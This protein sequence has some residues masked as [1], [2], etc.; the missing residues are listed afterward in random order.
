MS[1]GSLPGF[2]SSAGNVVEAEDDDVRDRSVAELMASLRSALSVETFEEVQKVLEAGRRSSDREAE[3]LRREN[4][5]F[6][7]EFV[8]LYLENIRLRGEVLEC[9]SSGDEC[10]VA[11]RAEDLYNVL[12]EKVGRGGGDKS[13]EEIVVELRRKND[14]LESVKRGLEGEKRE[15]ESQL[16]VWG[17]KYKELD[18]RLLQLERETSMCKNEEQCIL[19]HREGESAV[20][21][22]PDDLINVGDRGSTQCRS[23]SKGGGS[24]SPCAVRG[25]R[26]ILVQ[27]LACPP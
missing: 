23:D 14:E 19:G 11:E 16:R 13:L 26:W 3:R 7:D 2:A 22:E 1:C 15:L 6:R 9:R 8:R 10:G 24:V 18:Q 27:V 20:L 17:M 21:R 4:K 5:S 12:M 25:G